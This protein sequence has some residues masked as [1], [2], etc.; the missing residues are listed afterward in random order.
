MRCDGELAS[1]CMA[2]ELG[3]GDGD[4]AR[5]WVVGVYE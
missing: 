3:D 2:A 5:M 1:G 4:E